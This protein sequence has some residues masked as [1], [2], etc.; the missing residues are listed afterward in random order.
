MR[1]LPSFTFFV[2]TGLSLTSFFA[3]GQY[4]SSGGGFEVDYIKGCVPLTVT[5]TD[6]I[7]ADE[8]RVYK[9]NWDG[10]LSNIIVDPE[11]QIENPDTIYTEAGTYTILQ[12]RDG[13]DT[14]TIQI[15]VL[16]K[17]PPKY[18]VYNCIEN[19]IYIDFSQ[20]DYYD[21]LRIDFGDGTVDTLDV[22]EQNITHSY[23]GSAPQT[24]DISVEGI[25]EDA[26]TNC[27]VR[28]TTITTINELV[29]ASIEQV[30][31]LDQNRVQV[32][33]SLPDPNVAYRLE[34]AENG[35][36]D[37]LLATYDLEG[38]SSSF[39][40]EGFSD[41]RQS[42]YCFR[43]AAVD[44]CSGNQ[45]NSDPICSIALQATTGNL[46][47]NLN[48]E[49]NTT[50]FS[51]YQVQRDGEDLEV[52]SQ[53]SYED[54]DVECQ[55]VYEYQVSAQK[56][57]VESIS[58]LIALTAVTTDVL[59]AIDEFSVTTQGLGLALMWEAVPEA[60]QYYIYRE[61]NSQSLQVIDSLENETD[62]VDQQVEIDAEYC[63]QVSY[64]D[65]C[66]NE[67]Q[68][69]AQICEV[70]PRQGKIVFPNAFTPNGDDLNDVFIYKANLIERIELKIFNRWGEMIFYT[71]QIDTGWD[72]TYRGTLVPE[73][74][75]VY[76]AKIVDQLGNQF[77]QQGSFMLL[78]PNR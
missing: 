58:E 38:N 4:E 52:T 34:V 3:Y 51:S 63:Y 28:D 10:D 57:G 69:S 71:D 15:E 30:Q 73:G 43:I 16:E 62:Y 72:G 78:N 70:V 60:Q 7:P 49:T 32:D 39:V 47:N 41:T 46:V 9:F 22:S 33:Y 66:G 74:S 12:V 59:P 26:Q 65:A 24:H 67:S 23:S 35:D 19:S 68:M 48:W 17:L 25:F 44:W 61:G 5:V 14:S 27:A 2:L 40:V 8:P 55:Q 1:C 45:L 6:D 13:G 75:Y 76:Q 37:F 21:L 77:Q 11:Q 50:D 20:E 42:Y 29:E 18:R 36:T 64:L 31:V 53:T 54:G 56:N